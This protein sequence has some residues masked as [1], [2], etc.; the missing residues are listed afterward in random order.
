[1][2]FAW[3]VHAKGTICV[4]ICVADVLRGFLQCLQCF[5][6]EQAGRCGLQ[7]ISRTR[8]TCYPVSL[9]LDVLLIFQQFLLRNSFDFRAFLDIFK[10]GE[11]VLSRCFPFPD[12]NNNVRLLVKEIALFFFPF[13]D[14]AWVQSNNI[15]TN[16]NSFGLAKIG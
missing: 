11:F 5:G 8:L 15:N 10:V 1:M 9:S 12:L 14:F 16:I 13:N 7:S 3:N 6:G 2:Q 4:L